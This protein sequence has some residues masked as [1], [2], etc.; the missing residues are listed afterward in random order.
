M[1]YKNLYHIII[2][3]IIFSLLIIPKFTLAA[4]GEG[5]L[6]KGLS[7]K[8][9]VIENGLKRWIKTAEI[10]ND[11]GYLWA[12]IRHISEQTLNN[13][14]PGKDITNTYQYPDG[15][16]L[17]GSD[18]PVYLVEKGEFRWIPNPQI[19]TAKGFKWQNIIQI[20]DK[21][22]N[23][24]KKGRD[25]SSEYNPSNHRPQT[26]I[27]DGPCKQNQDTIPKIETDQVKFKYSGRNSQ[28]SATN[29]SFET[30]LIG[31]DENW[32]SSWFSYERKITLPPSNKI[33]TFCVRAKTQDGY[34]DITPASC[35]F[36]IN[37]SSYNK[38]IE[39][40]SVWGR[41]TNLNKEQVILGAGRSMEGVVNITGWT[42]KTKK[43]VPITIPK[44]VESVYSNS[45]YNFQRDLILEAGETVNI[46]GGASPIG[47]NAYRVNKCLKYFDDKLKYDACRYEHCRDPDFLKKE[48]RIYL[49][50]TSEFL[51]EEDEE[52]ILRDEYGLV[53]DKYNY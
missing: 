40:S 45:I 51:A 8:V 35:K 17:K 41:S 25:I 16:L 12:N 52:V 34:Y 50:R 30:F 36:R 6:I 22:L 19:F 2:I 11:F 53:V 15:T 3:L 37:L 1:T 33:Y 28:G 27:L 38:Q 31:Y 29:L 44:A 13:T 21:I 26:F 46:Y 7:D 9:Y 49:N 24:T 5:T 4:F 47:I 48:W 20:S 14:L 42:I 18:P 43:H 32:K 23:R 39:I 10:F